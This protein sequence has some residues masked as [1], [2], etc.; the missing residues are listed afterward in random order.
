[1][2]RIAKRLGIVEEKADYEEVSRALANL[3]DWEKDNDAI[4]YFWL[5]AKHICKAKNPR[6]KE[7]PLKNFCKFKK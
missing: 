5:L 6:C 3:F 2:F 7:C 1:M 4:S